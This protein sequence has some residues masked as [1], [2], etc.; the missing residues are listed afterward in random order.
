M[1]TRS[2]LFSIIIPTYNR[3]QKV[4]I[5]IASV[6]Y[7]TVT[8]WELL[9]VDDGS[10]KETIEILK[11]FRDDRIKYC[12]QEHKER[13]AARNL[14]ISNSTGQYIC[15]LDDDDYI[16]RDHLSTFLAHISAESPK[17]ILRSGYFTKQDGRRIKALLYSA[18]KHKH[19][20]TFFSNHMCGIWSLCIPREFLV[21]HKF[22]VLFP[23]WQDTHLA[24]R[25]LAYY[26]FEQ[27]EAW[28]YVYCQHE[29]MGSRALF[30]GPQIKTRTQFQ[31]DAIN[32]LFSKHG[33]VLAPFLSSG[34]Q[35]KL[36]AEKQLRGSALLLEQ[37]FV[38]DSWTMLGQSAIPPTLLPSGL[39]HLTKLLLSSLKKLPSY[40]I[41]RLATKHL[42]QSAQGSGRTC[43]C[44]SS[45]FKSF[46]PFGVITRPDAQCWHCGSLER[47]RLLWLYCER[48]LDL[49]QSS[50]PLNIL[51]I[52]PSK[53]FYE[54]FSQQQNIDYTA[55]D[56]APENYSFPVIEMDLTQGKES[57][58]IC[59]LIF[60]IHI[61]EHIVDE[62]AALQTIYKLLQLDGLA[63]IM[64]PLDI[65]RLQTKEMGGAVSA[66]LRQKHYGQV[67]HVRIYGLDFR[68][69]LSQLGFQVE[70]LRYASQ[71]TQE[72]IRRF[73]VFE[74]DIIFVCRKGHT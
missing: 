8:D 10:S 9:V 36:V 30:K 39:K 1:N 42:S 13:S 21:N 66:E 65:T 6:Q 28:T 73:G 55:G 44:C 47:H 25:L 2:P 70:E 34:T 20:V 4:R 68:D 62:A 32:D 26:P 54:Q 24:L 57:E 37:G 50:E 18:K 72:E 19:P 63:L 64:V 49:F 15:F 51:Q 59:D 22:P 58:A 69:T 33:S 48:E 29:N 45:E 27:L 71:L 11:K 5:A 56:T 14:G 17:K 23:H 38:R 61:L 43:P 7:Q 12:R 67:D 52:G 41:A 40:A 60:A 16:E 35:K 74:N 46:K 3:P 53:I 31:I